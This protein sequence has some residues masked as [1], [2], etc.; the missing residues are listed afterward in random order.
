MTE[1]TSA[2]R[3]DALARLAG[4][5]RRQITIATGIT[6]AIAITMA[7]W[8]GWAS[9]IVVAM[10]PLA[11]L[12]HLL[13]LYRVKTGQFGDNAREMKELAPFLTNPSKR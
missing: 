3:A 9:L 8:L 4:R 1:E 7:P 5:E 12:Q 11:I 13:T 6:V 10:I 2:R